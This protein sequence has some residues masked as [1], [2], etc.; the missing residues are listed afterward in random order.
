MDFLRRLAPLRDNDATRAVAVLPSRFAR[1]GLS[2]T[3]SEPAGSSQTAIGDGR[4]MPST[5][6]RTL[7]G[8]DRAPNSARATPGGLTASPTQR[9]SRAGMPARADSLPQ[10]SARP[11]AEP[12]GASFPALRDPGDR[13]A[14]APIKPVRSAGAEPRAAS[15]RSP[16]RPSWAAE[17]GLRAPL[18]A[19][20]VA[21]RTPAS[22]AEGSVVHVTIGRIDVVAAA[23]TAPGVRR[24]PK[25]P[26]PATVSLADYLRAGNGTRR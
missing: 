18:S 3:A 23:P 26:H 19:A 9:P 1:E 11:G 8:L 24:G 21:L 16:E 12:P 14:T 7:P 25:A 10:P 5:S 15:A 17:P 4:D 13:P 2:M 6:A 22:R 20:T